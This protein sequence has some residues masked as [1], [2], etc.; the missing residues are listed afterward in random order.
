MN[1]MLGDDSFSGAPE[2]LS[3]FCL[4]SFRQVAAFGRSTIRK[5]PYNVADLSKL[6]ARDY[7]DILQCCIPCFEGLLPSPHNETILHLLYIL[8]Y[9]HSLAKLR[10]HTDTTIRIF[11]QTTTLL[12]DALRYFTNETCK[13]FK[14][15]ETD[16]EYQART[17][18]TARRIAKESAP[19]ASSASA[20]E[21]PSAPA[22]GPSSAP[23]P[24]PSSVPVP[25]PSSAPVPGL[26]SAPAGEP[27][28]ASAPASTLSQAGPGTSSAAV[29]PVQAG[30]SSTSTAP[31]SG[32]AGKRPKFFNITTPKMH[33]FPDYAEQIEALGTTDNLSTQLV[34]D[35]R[36]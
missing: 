11:R 24:G 29:P 9:W 18:A 4:Y 7:E 8:N 16:K 32:R 26:S 20:P 1:L 21:P 6:A 22:P 13:A 3:N 10:M 35:R 31:Q 28:S 23:V 17:R 33:F 12:G 15:F 19:S 5:F 2:Y 34:S 36:I 25:G 27:S 14:T 30:L